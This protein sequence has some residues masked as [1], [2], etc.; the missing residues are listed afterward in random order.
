[1]SGG[2][3]TPRKKESGQAVEPCTIGKVCNVDAVEDSE[4]NRVNETEK[5]NNTSQAHAETNSSES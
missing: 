2:V 3:I 5:K 1:M 4:W